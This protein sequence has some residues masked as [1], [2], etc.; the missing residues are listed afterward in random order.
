MEEYLNNFQQ[1]YDYDSE[2]MTTLSKIIPAICQYYG[3][4]N[5]ESVLA[6]IASCPIHIEKKGESASHFLSE[7]FPFKENGVV[8]KVATGFYDSAPVVEHD[9]VKSKKILYI[10]KG[11]NDLQS[12]SCLSTM[13][14]ELVHVVKSYK[15]EYFY[16]DGVLYKR[17]GISVTKMEYNELGQVKEGKGSGDGLEEAVTCF[18]EDNIMS[19]IL[20]REYTANSYFGLAKLAGLLSQKTDLLSIIYKEQLYNTGQLQE[21][22]GKE[23]F[24]ELI[25]NSDQFYSLTFAMPDDVVEKYKEYAQNIKNFIN[26]YQSRKKESDIKLE[27]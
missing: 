3:Q 25:D 21:F 27:I 8:P 24:N 20:G 10:R 17:S 4:N 16:Q 15:D 12:E 14:H 7:Y 9:E 6:A 23:N 19:M 1:L 22:L 13:V 18:D 11:E 26:K 2:L 5:E